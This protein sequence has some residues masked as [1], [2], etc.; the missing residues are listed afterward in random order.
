MADATIIVGKLDDKQLTTSIEALVKLV[1]KNTKAMVNSFS[2]AIDDINKKLAT[3]GNGVSKATGDAS[4]KRASD[5]QKEKQKVADLTMTY[6]QMSQAVRKITAEHGAVKM[7][8]TE[9]DL[10]SY[11]VLLRRLQA[12]FIKVN[13]Q[14]GG[15]LKTDK[16]RAE[17]D[18][19]NQIINKYTAA[20]NALKHVNSRQGTYD[21]KKWIQDLGALDA[22]YKHLVNW[23]SQLRARQ[24]LWAF[25]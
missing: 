16:M 17:I 12:E 21:S 10:Q 5:L 2:T 18:A 8:L 3:I 23:Y 15:G 22:R 1:D 20:M 14:E 11:I 25:L 6:D 13:T 9:S 4:S 19:L 24:Q 7:G